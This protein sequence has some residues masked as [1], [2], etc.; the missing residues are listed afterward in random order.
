MRTRHDTAPD[1]V[2]DYPK[3]KKPFT[4]GHSRMDRGDID[5]ARD[6][7]YELLGW[8]RRTGAPTA[9]CLKRL[10]LGDVAAGLAASGLLPA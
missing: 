9:A 8:D 10:G 3:D 6:M 4:P 2:F 7:F 5:R 1:W